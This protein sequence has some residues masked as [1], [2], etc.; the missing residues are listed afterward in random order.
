MYSIGL[1]Q[2]YLPIS[3]NAL[4]KQ[5]IPVIVILRLRALGYDERRRG[6]GGWI[7]GL[8]K[9]H[10]FVKHKIFILWEPVVQW[11]VVPLAELL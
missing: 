1:A 3:G 9:I 8:S 10:F 4:Q 5:S 7:K 11:L 6:E 2:L